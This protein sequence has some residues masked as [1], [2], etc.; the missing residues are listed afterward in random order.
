MLI[1]IL[2]ACKIY[3]REAFRQN[4]TVV[5]S[6]I[7]FLVSTEKTTYTLTLKVTP[8]STLL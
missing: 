7:L 3:V 6:N 4:L 1:N 8:V 2:V 5:C